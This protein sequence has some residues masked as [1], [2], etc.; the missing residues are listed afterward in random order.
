MKWNVISIC[1]PYYPDTGKF[2]SELQVKILHC[3]DRRLRRPFEVR[4]ND[5][6]WDWV[7]NLREAVESANNLLTKLEKDKAKVKS[8]FRL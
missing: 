4:L 8:W 2:D 6:G 5:K 1:T 7:S 3:A